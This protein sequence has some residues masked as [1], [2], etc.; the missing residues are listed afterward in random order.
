ML[1]GLYV[2]ML[3]SDLRL[4]VRRWSFEPDDGLIEIGVRGRGAVRWPPAVTLDD[5]LAEQTSRA[6]L[7]YARSLL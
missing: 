5:K 2:T 7:T 1:L 4:L 3:R 6:V